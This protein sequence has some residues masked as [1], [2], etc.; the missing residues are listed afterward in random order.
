MSYCP[1]DED[2]ASA[3]CTADMV[4]VNAVREADQIWIEG[5]EPWTYYKLAIAMTSKVVLDSRGF[6]EHFE[7]N[8]HTQKAN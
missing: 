7:A 3:P 2:D 4:V 5:L 6:F 1:V 8:H